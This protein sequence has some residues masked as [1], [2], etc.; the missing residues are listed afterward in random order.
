MSPR[1][2]GSKS[3]LPE[4]TKFPAWK[5][6][7]VVFIALWRLPG[8][9][10]QLVSIVCLLS[11]KVAF[12]ASTPLIT[13][14]MK[15]G[16]I[17]C[18]CVLIGLSESGGKAA[19]VTTGGDLVQEKTGETFFAISRGMLFFLNVRLIS[20]GKCSAKASSI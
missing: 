15:I 20:S 14:F 5:E 19:F 12:R 18:F 7:L 17:L 6:F 10:M 13:W 8:P 9:S 3:A 16:G 2:S 11:L 1:M 4:S